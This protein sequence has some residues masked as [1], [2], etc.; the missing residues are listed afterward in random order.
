MDKI[1]KELKEGKFVTGI[2]IDLSK[3]FDI[4]DHEILL[5]KLNHY[6]IRGTTVNWFKHYLHDQQQFTVANHESST[7]RPVNY[8][9]P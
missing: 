5:N 6:G 2:Y 4:V 3:A 9:V 7:L 8:G 1:Q